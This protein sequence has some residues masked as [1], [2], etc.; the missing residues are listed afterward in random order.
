MLAFFFFL[1]FFCGLQEQ[2]AAAAACDFYHNCQDA[3]LP[4]STKMAEKV[5]GWSLG[6]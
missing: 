2:L 5:L 6:V 1:V 4:L 3:D